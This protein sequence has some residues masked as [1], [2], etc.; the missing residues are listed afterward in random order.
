MMIERASFIIDD[1]DASILRGAVAHLTDIGY[2]ETNVCERLGVSDLTE[3][4]WRLVPIYREERLVDR[5]TL[6]LAIDFFLLQ[7][8]VI[9]DELNQLFTKA[10]Q[11]ALLRGGLLFIDGQKC[12]AKASLF[13]VGNHLIFSDHAWPKL[14]HPGYSD[15]PHNQVMY[16][17]TDSRWLARTTVRKPFGSALDL[18]TGSGIHAILAA[19]HSQR[20]V[21]VDISPRA[22]LCVDFN[23]KA[24]GLSNVEAKIGDLF[25]PILDERFDLITANPPFVPSPVDSLGY[26]DGG[27]SG[28]DVLRRIVAGLPH[29]LASG[30]IAQ[31][32][33]EMGEGDDESISERLRVWLD[34]A[35]M[36]ILIL[37]VGMY[38]AANYAVGH[39][40]GDDTYGAFFDSVHD[41]ADNLRTNGYTK[42]VS[43]L[44]IFQWSDLALGAPWTR[45][46]E[47]QPPH[48]DAGAEVEEMFIAEHIIR[49]PFLYETLKNARLCR[50][51][52]IE[53]TETMALDAKV[54]TNTQTQLLKKALSVFRWIN[55]VE[56]ELLL[57]LEKPLAM[58]EILAITNKLNIQEQTVFVAVGSLLRDRLVLLV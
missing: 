8:V 44:L 26:R 5:D 29:H 3:L 4:S 57:M 14:P 23:A 6:G 35:P 45:I 46:E 43:V 49:Q 16:I 48:R 15:V 53:L 36:D 51:E 56:R 34:G 58:S 7:G 50:A 22:T 2:C 18:C 39:A 32:V 40:D 13:P 10:E 41:W 17:G 30:G 33:T 24:S 38:S 19:F 52:Q 42:V 12:F 37:R 47:S 21:A 31:I 9:E 55:P 11:D 1:S 25:E 27:S 28:E 54:C 20:V